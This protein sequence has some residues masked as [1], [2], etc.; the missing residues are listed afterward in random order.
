M[1]LPAE[2]PERAGLLDGLKD[3]GFKLSTTSGITIGIDEKLDPS[4]AAAA[5]TAADSARSTP[6]AK[7]SSDSRLE[8]RSSIPIRYTL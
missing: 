7:A 8:A 1:E 3:A 2:A 6:A 5:S 4:L